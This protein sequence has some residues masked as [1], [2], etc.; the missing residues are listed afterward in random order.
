MDSFDYAALCGELEALYRS[1]GIMPRVIARTVLGRAVFALEFG[2]RRPRTLLLAGVG[3]EGTTSRCLLRF[4]KA[5][6]QHQREQVPFFGVDLSCALRETGVTVI[7]CLN[8]DGLELAVHGLSAAGPL[9]RFLRPLLG[10][11]SL[12][13][14]NARGV[15]LHHQFDAGFYDHR[16]PDIDA[17]CAGGFGGTTPQSEAES[18][19]LTSLCRGEQFRHALLLQPGNNRLTVFAPSKNNSTA[20]LCG[21]LLA[22]ELHTAP[23]SALLPDGA[24]PFW[25]SETMRRPAYIV[26]TGKESDPLPESMLFSCLLLSVLL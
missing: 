17:P 3:G 15:D 14:A 23:Q 7:P 21:K 1:D 12:W 6:L 8:P 13:T 20:N 9:R 19:A 24:F 4:C 2:K 18:R 10:S 5:L 22:Q 16:A 25:F 26:Q 11:Q